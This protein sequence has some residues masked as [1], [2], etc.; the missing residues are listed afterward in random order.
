VNAIIRNKCADSRAHIIGGAGDKMPRALALT[1]ADV[2]HGERRVYTASY[3]C[4]D[5]RRYDM[6][7]TRPAAPWRTVQPQQ[8]RGPSKYTHARTQRSAD[9]SSRTGAAGRSGGWQSIPAT[10]APWDIVAA[11][12][13]GASCRPLPR[14]LLRLLPRLLSRL[15]R[16]HGYGRMSATAETPRQLRRRYA[17]TKRRHS[18]ATNR[19][20]RR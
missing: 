9:V 15:R 12:S 11:S 18:V 14:P 4:M 10:A 17:T 5:T 1:S 6:Q 3:V 19:Q 16:C 13:M 2:G 20:C 7:D 8:R